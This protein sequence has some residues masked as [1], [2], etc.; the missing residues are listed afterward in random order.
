MDTDTVIRLP[1]WSFRLTKPS[2]GLLPGWMASRYS[3]QSKVV[4][5]MSVKHAIDHTH[6]AWE[7]KSSSAS[8]SPRCK[9][10]LKVPTQELITTKDEESRAKYSNQTAHL[11]IGIQT[12]VQIRFGI[13]TYYPSNLPKIDS[14][15]RDKQFLYI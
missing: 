2:E 11:N 12:N 8:I 1:V 13:A 14:M 10:T 15:I 4:S 9:E 3:H 5:Q 6:Q 7:S